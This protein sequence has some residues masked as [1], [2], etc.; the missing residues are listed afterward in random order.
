MWSTVFCHGR[1]R[2]ASFK[3]ISNWEE[4]KHEHSSTVTIDYQ[5]WRLPYEKFIEG[6]FRH[7]IFS[8]QSFW[9]RQKSPKGVWISVTFSL[10]IVF[11]TFWRR[12]G[13]YSSKNAHTLRSNRVADRHANTFLDSSTSCWFLQEQAAD[14]IYDHNHNHQHNHN[15][16][17]G[18]LRPLEQTYHQTQVDW[19]HSR[20]GKNRCSTVKIAQIFVA[21]GFI[22]L[23][24]IAFEFS[25]PTYVAHSADP[26]VINH[27]SKEPIWRWTPWIHVMWST[28]WIFQVF[29]HL[30]QIFSHHSFS[31]LSAMLI[32][33]L[34]AE[35]ELESKF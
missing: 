32:S 24:A 25:Q 23:L 28:Q 19:P 34:K 9:A 18:L 10:M 29:L 12:E 6:I 1:F 21:L 31:F 3:W 11:L 7:R 27:L 35:R 8:F 16:N 22:E 13:N 30:G 15:D 5:L 17:L 20:I 4:H 26:E 33:T 14:F 2:T